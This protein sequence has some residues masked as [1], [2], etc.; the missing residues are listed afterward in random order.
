VQQWWLKTALQLVREGCCRCINTVVSSSSP[1]TLV[2]GVTACSGCVKKV[3]END[4][5]RHGGSV[6]T[7]ETRE[8]GFRC[9][10]GSWWSKELVKVV[11]TAFGM[12][13]VGEEENKG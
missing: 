7:A 1:T 10:S 2:R 8:D 13:M 11:V 5:G 3:V 4:G 12:V 6:I 9:C